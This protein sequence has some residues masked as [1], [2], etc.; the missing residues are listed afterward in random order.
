MKK[1]LS[2]LA[3]ASFAAAITLTGSIPAFAWD[4][5]DAPSG[6]NSGTSESTV[7]DEPDCI[8]LNEI[9][10]EFSADLA[11]TASTQTNISLYVLDSSY[12]DML[13][14]PESYNQCYQLGKY[15]L[16]GTLTY[17]VISGDSVK[18]SDS[19]LVEP[20]CEVWYW[21]N[22]FGS[23]FPMDGATKTYEYI[24]GKSVV[25]ISNGEKTKDIT[26]NVVNY[27][28]QY[29]DEVQKNFI[30]KNISDSM[31]EYQKLEAIT[32]Y[33]A[34]TYNYSPYYSS[35][36]SMIISGGGDCWASCDLIMSLC[37]L[38]GIKNHVRIA[39]RDPGAGSGHRNV[40]ALCDG[41]LYIADAG[42][43]GDA[44]RTRDLHET[45]AFSDY[46]GV[47]YQY[48]GFDDDI[49]IP[50]G[51]TAIG[52]EN[53]NV[54]YYSANCDSIT[55]ISIPSSVSY[56]SNI[57]FA[58][59]GKLKN[60]YVDSANKYYKTIDGILYT[61]DGRTIYTVP[62]GKSKVSIPRGVTTIGDY[63]FYYSSSISSVSIPDTVTA[64]GVGA[65]GDCLSLSSITIPKSV[66]TIADY[67]FYD[68]SCRVIVLSNDVAFGNNVAS[69]C[70]LVGYSGSTT[71]KYAK[72]NKISFIALESDGRYIS[73]SNGKTCIRD[74]Y[75]KIVN[76]TGLRN[77]KGVLTYFK[78]GIKCNDKTLVKYKN[79]YYFVK[80]GTICRTRAL[81]KYKNRYYYVKNG[82][83]FRK[84][85]ITE[86][87][88]K[89]YYIKNGIWSS[90]TTALVKYNKKTYYIKN[91]AV[92][93]KFTGLK[94]YK[95]HVYSVR[96]GVVVKKVR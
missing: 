87:N 80:N 96:K 34:D 24:T 71:E 16:T 59:T 23:S 79:K 55:S 93:T 61:K 37:D 72:E 88:K 49:V 38:V 77:V 60:L 6:Y 95:G 11:D 5:Y 50:E 13:T 85:L 57:A 2:F 70:T 75:G 17:E 41:K 48:D 65:F 68:D 7:S 69:D 83:I 84:T 22:G 21:L 3:V 15:G 52:E 86:L 40:V 90:K 58:G 20:N 19:G 63:C 29:T 51:I 67:A 45:T 12:A 30:A 91:G 78:N 43:D 81:V 33:V 26:F 76:F 35:G 28:Y 9:E 46:D 25:R 10:R 53:Q 31:T 42:Y 4:S 66:K 56:I 39:N 73:K 27:A 92:Y 14:I 36:M 18:V 82:T 44:P 62:N 8:S 94:K 32:N 1:G 47:L 64:I 89:K 54:F 74:G